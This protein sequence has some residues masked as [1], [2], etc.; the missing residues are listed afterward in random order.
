MFGW[1][2]WQIMH[3]LVG[4]ERVSVCLS[5]WPGSVLLMVGSTVCV[6]P[7]WPNFAYSARV[8]RVAVVR[9]HDV[10]RRAARVAVVAG[11]IVGA[12]EPGERIVEARLGDV[13]HRHRDA[14]ARAR[15]AV[16]LAE[17]GP[18]RLLDPLQLAGRVR[19]AGLREQVR[20]VAA[21]ALEHAEDVAGLERFPGRQRIELRQDARDR[22]CVDQVIRE[23]SGPSARPPRRRGRT[24]RRGCSA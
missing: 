13:D 4:T 21:A 16:R 14:R 3:W 10:A 1:C 9:V 19:Q 20:D 2:M 22:R 7:S 24:P 11:L 6:R 8:P 15:A 12:D 23:S 5:G 18:A 17:V